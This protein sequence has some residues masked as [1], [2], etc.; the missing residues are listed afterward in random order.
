[1]STTTEAILISWRY[2]DSNLLNSTERSTEFTRD[3]ENMCTD[4]FFP[5]QE[6]SNQHI[7]IFSLRSKRVSMKRV[8]IIIM[9][10]W[11]PENNY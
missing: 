1:M 6:I 11:S 3:S 5:R 9:Q 7:Y 4:L 10:A 2:R 8:W